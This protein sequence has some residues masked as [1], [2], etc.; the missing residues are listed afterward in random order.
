MKISQIFLFINASFVNYEHKTP[1]GRKKTEKCNIKRPSAIDNLI[2]QS[3]TKQNISIFKKNRT[4]RIQIQN[5]IVVW[6][7]F[8]PKQKQA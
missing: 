3:F 5:Y 7:T 2:K 8:Q 4:Y 1:T 6:I